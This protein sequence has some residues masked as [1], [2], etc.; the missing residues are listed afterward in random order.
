MNK[1]LKVATLNGYLLGLSEFNGNIREYEFGAFLVEK[2]S[3]ASVSDQLKLVFLPQA[4]LKIVS[5]E[6]LG[7][8]LHNLERELTNYI[9]PKYFL[10]NLNSSVEKPI[11]D[12]KNYLVFRLMDYITDITDYK[13]YEVL[14]LEATAPESP[15]LATFFCL[16][17]EKHILVLQF[18]HNTP[19]SD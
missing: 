7:T 1:N 6:S 3:K 8:T 9:L 15:S 2:T 12:R 19:Y 16:C 10:A 13:P 5:S 4:H 18:N 11:D 17:Y 14:K